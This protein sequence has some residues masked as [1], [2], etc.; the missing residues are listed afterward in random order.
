[1]AGATGVIGK[2]GLALPGLDISKRIIGMAV[3][4]N[5][6][7]SRLAEGDVGESAVEAVAVIS[8]GGFEP[9][10]RVRVGDLGERPA[11]SALGIGEGPEM[12]PQK[13]RRRFTACGFFNSG[14]I[15]L[16]AGLRHRGHLFCRGVR[17]GR[18]PSG[19]PLRPRARSSFP[20]G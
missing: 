5:G 3:L 13:K 9:G 20:R 7:S 1:M 18:G 16:V 19:V 11:D 14:S 10:I 17:R 4:G 2:L 15:R 8:E 6:G 12:P